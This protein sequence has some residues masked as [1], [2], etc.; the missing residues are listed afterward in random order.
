VTTRPRALVTDAEE[1][2]A[3]AV[4]RG[5][6]AAG[7]EVI[8]A[9]GRT[10]AA[11]HWSRSASRRVKLPD[12]RDGV[13]EYVDR[14][15][16]AVQA[17]QPDVV[18]AAAEVS[19]LPISEHR[20]RFPDVPTGLPPHEVVLRA[21]DKVL[22]QD[23]AERIGLGP[24][25]S[26][27][28]STSAEASEAARAIGF[29]VLVKPTRSLSAEGTGLRQDQAAVAA[30][31]DELTRALG[32]LGLP[33]TVQHYVADAR[34]VS[35]GGVQVG[36]E[37]RGLTVARYLRTFPPSVGS[38]SMAITVPPP[39]GLAV[40]AESLL[41][42][43]GWEG[44]FELELLELGPGRFAAIDLNPRPF[45]WM[46]LCEGA[47]ANLAAIWCDRVLGRSS[48][49]SPAQPGV[50]YRWE[51][52]DAR[53]FLRRLRAGQVRQ[54]AAVLRPRR[55]VVHALFRIADP[56]PLA[57]RLA[58][59]AAA[60]L[61]RRKR[62]GPADDAR[63]AEARPQPAVAAEEADPGQGVDVAA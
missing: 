33:V 31:E 27:V 47:G 19:L 63:G 56:G 39:D 49:A 53:H 1:R 9:A 29:P 43:I 12:P 50:W 11:A 3:L 32:S 42:R 41:H 16:D 20:H 30:D 60:P 18:V 61:R 4:C 21:V 8:A 34:I 10:P 37:I 14:L 6:A 55:H 58:Y 2:A 52:A 48:D 45:G 44:I 62:G 28:C 26:A 40:R 51:D 15:A 38:A 59:M 35:I 13:G 24:P 54:A 5:L 7:Y 57:A 23:E 17:T 46:T 36:G 22:L 25:P